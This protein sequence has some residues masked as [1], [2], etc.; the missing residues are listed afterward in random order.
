MKRRSRLERA[1]IVDGLAARGGRLAAFGAPGAAA[2]LGTPFGTPG[3]AAALGTPFDERCIPSLPRGAS[4]VSVRRQT[5]TTGC[6]AFLDSLS[7]DALRKDCRR[8]PLQRRRRSWLRGLF[9]D[10]I[11]IGH[12][13]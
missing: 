11:L 5:F 10:V 8:A 7:R 2:A 12:K 6:Q 1:A 3:A 4:L 13:V 9:A